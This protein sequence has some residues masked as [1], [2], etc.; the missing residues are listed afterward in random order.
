M[1]VR[2]MTILAAA[3]ALCTAPA[4]Y[5]QTCPIETDVTGASIRILSN[6]FPALHAV[7]E[8]AQACAG[9]GN[10][11]SINAT[12]E[13]K[14][15][16]VA[17]LTANPA[18][19]S[20]A[21]VANGSLVPLLADGLV[22][23]L[24]DLADKFNVPQRQRITINGK[25]MAIAFMANSQHLFYRADLLEKAGIEPPE[26]Y[27]Q[28][29]AA[30]KAIEEQGIME[31]PLALNTGVGWHL[32][33]EFV[34]MHLGMGGDFFAPGSAEPAINN[35]TG[36]KTLEM[37]KSL[38]EYSNPDFLTFD[39]NTTNGLWSAGQLALMVHWGSRADQITGGQTPDDIGQNTVLS[40]MPTV[41]D[42]DKAAATLW[43]DG[44]SI[45]TNVSDKDAEASFVAM[46]NA[47]QPEILD[48]HTDK[49]VWIIE[50]YEPGPAAVGVQETM[51]TGATPYPMTPYM[52]ILHGVLG[53]EL[54]DYLQG[55]ESAEDALD[56]IE[57]SYIAAARE[58]GFLQ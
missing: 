5:S 57:Q 13:H 31:H 41:A 45:A 24:D 52:G 36:V 33:E 32:G 16:Q 17:A 54:T 14:N 55:S 39:G 6:D 11:V 29:L 7:N 40:G 35:E 25:T 21:V 46:L 37:L 26:T 4:A 38:T 58:Q 15:I 23:P 49:A 44:F 18:E 50:G 2:N 53:E 20:V 8:R 51:A 12:A 47:I 10:E 42:G 43:W 9:S 3:V 19:Y 1:T 22:R 56:D 28:V 48:S 30:A 27:E 34:N